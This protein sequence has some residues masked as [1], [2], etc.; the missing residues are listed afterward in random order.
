MEKDY[1]DLFDGDDTSN[2]GDFLSDNAVEVPF[3]KRTANDDE[4]ADDF[5]LTSG[6][7]RQR[8]HVLEDDDNSVGRN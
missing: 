5:M 8:S 4:D 6:R 7:L 3:S 1:D 2:T